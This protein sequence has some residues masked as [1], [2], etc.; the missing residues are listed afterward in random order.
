MC[1]AL[2]NCKRALVDVC[3]L[4]LRSSSDSRFSNS[5]LKATNY[6]KFRICLV[7]IACGGIIAQINQFA[8]NIY[9]NSCRITIA[10]PRIPREM[11]FIFHVNE[12]Q[13]RILVW[14]LA[15]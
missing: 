2:D 7:G 6:M 10:L 11:S 3:A 5:M 9:F 14:A 1:L 12:Y 15:F 4:D 13:R 8:V